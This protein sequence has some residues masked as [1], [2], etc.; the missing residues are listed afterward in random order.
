MPP[1]YHPA[2]DHPVQR[3]QRADPPAGVGSKTLTEQQLFDLGLNFLR[4]QLATVQGASFPLPYGGK[5]RQ[6]MVDLDPRALQADGLTP[7]DVG[8]A[9][10][11][12]NLTLP[13]GTIKV[14]DR[15]YNVLLNNSPDA[16]ADLGDLPV[17]RPTGATIYIRDV[18]QVRDGYAAQTNIVRAGRPSA[19]SSLTI[20]KNGEASTLDII[21][22]LK[23]ALPR[24]KSTLRPSSTSCR[25]ST[26]RSSSGRRSTASSGKASSPPS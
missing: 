16:I 11:A 19:A 24:V 4:V 10:N 21:N 13:S 7:D 3:L 15:E 23:A 6:I 14:G 18:A 22:R 17:R 2:A 12:Q 25:C 1:G 26:S 9:I 20:L 8:T 5:V